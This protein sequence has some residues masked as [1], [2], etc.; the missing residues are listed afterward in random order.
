M[1]A[2]GEQVELLVS[3]D[4]G[5]HTK[6]TP[7]S[8]ATIHHGHNLTDFDIKYGRKTDDNMASSD[9]F[10]PC[11]HGVSCK[12]DQVLNFIERHIPVITVIRTYRV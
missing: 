2:S 8:H 3:A 4:T 1:A 12:R 5:E 6:A 11:G 9:S 10:L 7:S